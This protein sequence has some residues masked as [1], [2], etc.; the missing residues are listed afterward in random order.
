[1]E[2]TELLKKV[3]EQFSH[4]VSSVRSS[5]A[6][7]GKTYRIGELARV[8]DATTR[9]LRYYEELGLLEPV[10]NTSGQRLYGDDAIKRLGFI[11]ELKSGGFS[12][13]EIKSFFESWRSS[14]T[15]AEAAEASMGLINQKLADIAQL[16]K[17]LSR[18]NDELRS[19]VSFLL[20][21]QTCERQ[22]SEANCNPC[23]RHPEGTPEI[24]A[25][26]LKREV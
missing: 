8:T 7:L 3:E 6:G 4:V 11:N 14:K 20:T 19:M 23:A 9:T 13:L 26:I 18:L 17:K 21:C 2:K 10:R 15:G 22:P 16:Q 24:L 1:V 25:N 12:L 5:N